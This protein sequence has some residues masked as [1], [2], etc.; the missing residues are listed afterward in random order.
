V[1]FHNLS[2]CHMSTNIRKVKALDMVFP[3]ASP[4]LQWSRRERDQRDLFNIMQTA[5][6]EVHEKINIDFEFVIKVVYHGLPS[7]FE[8]YK[9]RTD[10]VYLAAS[11]EDEIRLLKMMGKPDDNKGHWWHYE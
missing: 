4:T 1:K 3:L 8:V 10:G 2:D 6:T 9:V 11:L 7:E 5:I